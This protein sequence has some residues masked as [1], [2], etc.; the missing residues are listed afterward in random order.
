MLMEIMVCLGVGRSR[1][2]SLRRRTRICLPALRSKRRCIPSRFACSLGSIPAVICERFLNSFSLVFSAFGPGRFWRKQCLDFQRPVKFENI[3][4]FFS[5][6]LLGL[7]LA[8]PKPW[9][10]FCL[11]SRSSKGSLPRPPSL[12]R[13]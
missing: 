4:G 11:R 8:R 2:R 13:S 3:L 5:S 12:Q 9:Q 6:I 10:D 1:I 7:K